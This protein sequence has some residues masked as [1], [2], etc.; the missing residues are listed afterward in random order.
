MSKPIK[1]ALAGAGAFGIKHLDAIKL[2]DGVEVVSLV[3]RELEK[4]RETAAQYGIG[5]VTTDLADSLALSAVDAVILCTP[6]QMHA[7]QAIACM[8]AGKHVQVEIPLADSLAGAEAVVT[9][10]QKT[11]LVAMCGH[12]RRFN[13]SHQW[14]H[15]KIGAGEFNIQQMDVQTYFFRRS[16]MNALGQARS[17]TDHLLWHHAAHTVD[18]FAYQTG[19]TIVAANALQGPIHPTLG[20]AMDMS[21][22][23]K[24][25]TG[26]ICTLS[27]SF[28]NDGPLGTFFRYIGD[29][30]TYIARYDD[31]IDA[32]D[33][34]IDV[35]KVDVS[36]NGIELQDREFFAAIREGREP[37]GSVAQVLPCYRTLHGLEQQL[38]KSA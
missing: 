14:V 12:T 1:V 7:A 31:L 20:I 32:K 9:L 22:Q 34:K 27:L 30:G 25:S 21:I 36:M 8:N 2:I 3:S 18:L 10:Q 19:G 5:H 17:W 37:N 28:N 26:A 38:A 4:T 11:G 13:P 24:S 29:S 33:N 6:T 35:S 15:K 23:L 16:N